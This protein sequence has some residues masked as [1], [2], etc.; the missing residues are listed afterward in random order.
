MELIYNKQKRNVS[1]I[2]SFI[3]NKMSSMLNMKVEYHNICMNE[4][5]IR[6]QSTFVM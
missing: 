2:R 3:R 4:L 6:V 1:F 5:K